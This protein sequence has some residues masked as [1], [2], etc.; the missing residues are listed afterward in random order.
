M[1]EKAIFD[2]DSG[3]HTRHET[4]TLID[5][6]D[7][8]KEIIEIKNNLIHDGK[9]KDDENIKR[10]LDNLIKEYNDFPTYNGYKTIK[11]I[12]KKLPFKES[13][14][15]GLNLETLYIVKTLELLKEKIDNPKS[16]YKISINGE[17]TNEIMEDLYLFEKK[18]FKNLKALNLN[19]IKLKDISA[20]SSCS[21]PNLVSLDF[22]SNEITN[23][24]IKIFKD[25]NLP[26][27]IDI[28]LFDNKISNTEIFG[29]IEKYQTLETF[30]IGKNLFDENIIK[31]DKNNYNFPPK[32]DSLGISYNFTKETN[33]F[34]FKNLNIKNIKILYIYGNE[35]NTLEQFEEIE[36]NRLVEL[37]LRGN[38]K[39]GYITDIEEIKHL[40]GKENIKKLILK[41]NIIKNIDKLVEII[42]SFPNLQLLN[43]ED[44][45][46]DSYKIEEVLGKIKEI[47]GHEN[48]NI[49]YNQKPKEEVKIINFIDS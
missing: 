32:L 14:N 15:E 30:Y 29:V 5:L 9:L 22:E 31:K 18:E 47:K 34:I 13:K 4:H 33:Y 10:L 27:I 25:L 6:L 3:I 42:P 49:K 2:N 12:L 46:I 17:K 36:F 45:P 40:K 21:F 11:K 38:L 26:K 23:D 44:N 28:C 7:V 41:E 20:L 48:I 37:W 24:C 8:K 16:I 35:F 19:N 39:K 1:V 43:L